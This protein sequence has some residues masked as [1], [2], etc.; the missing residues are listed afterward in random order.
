[1]IRRPPRSTLF[2][3][4]T[5]FRSLEELLVEVRGEADEDGPRLV[6]RGVIVDDQRELARLVAVVRVRALERAQ[7]DRRQEHL[8]ADA[9]HL[10]DDPVLEPAAQP[11]AE[12][13]DHARRPPAR[14]SPV[15]ASAS[16]S[17]TWLGR[18]SVSSR[19]S[20]RTRSWIWA[21]EALPNAAM[22]RLTSA[23]ARA[24]TGT[25]CCSAARQITPPAR[26]VGKAVRGNV[27]PAYRSSMTTVDGAYSASRRS[28][29]S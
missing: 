5:L 3:Y 12:G 19:S 20:R 21:F 16:A 28:T 13:G 17:A 24:S 8:V 23:G 11:S 1:M 6:A 10:E 14:E 2:P 9:A 7:R 25:L 27:Y 4:T 29:P 18:G 26:A 15:S 22:A